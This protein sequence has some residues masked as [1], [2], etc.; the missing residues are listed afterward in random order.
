MLAAVLDDLLRKQIREELGAT[1]S[2]FVYNRSSL[3]DPGYGVLR[4][5]MVVDPDQAVLLTEKLKQ[6]G[7]ELVTGKVHN[8]RT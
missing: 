5:G 2:P 1:Y 3:V 6:A 4:S 7:A 8:G